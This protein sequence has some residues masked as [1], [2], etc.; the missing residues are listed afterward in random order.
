MSKPWNKFK[1]SPM[2]LSEEE[3]IICQDGRE[4]NFP[5]RSFVEV[6]EAGAVKELK[7]LLTKANAFLELF[8]AGQRRMSHDL[9]P[10]DTSD[11]TLL[12]LEIKTQLEKYDKESL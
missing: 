10:K 1:I 2:G 7:D 6:V 11:A 3:D 8:A 4:I 12:Y 9:N 5:E